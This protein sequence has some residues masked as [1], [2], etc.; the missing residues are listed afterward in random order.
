MDCVSTGSLVWVSMDFKVDIVVWIIR[1]IDLKIIKCKIISAIKSMEIRCPG[2]IATFEKCR[3][4][5]KKLTGK[6]IDL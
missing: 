5:F 6:P 4:V 1:S 2:I 3:G